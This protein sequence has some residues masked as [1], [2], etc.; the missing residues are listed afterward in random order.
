MN[1]PPPPPAFAREDKKE[2]KDLRK[3]IKAMKFRIEELEASKIQM[4]NKVQ[5]F[6]RTLDL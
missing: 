2:D 3:S 5:K 1:S 6:C 4:E